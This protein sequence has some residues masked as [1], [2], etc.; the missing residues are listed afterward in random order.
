VA[1]PS[2]YTGSALSWL[3]TKARPWNKKLNDDQRAV[4]VDSAATNKTDPTAFF[5]RL[6]SACTELGHDARGAGQVQKAPTESLAS[7]WKEMTDRTATYA[8]DCLALTRTRSN[9]D[10]TRWNTSLRSLNLAN[11]ALNTIVASVRS[12][13]GG[14]SG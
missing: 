1:H 10:F 8:D 4:L 9:A 14:T 12:A 3:S 6:K 7:A 13:S 5:T 11:A 2:A